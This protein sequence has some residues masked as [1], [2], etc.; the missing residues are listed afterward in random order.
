MEA[1]NMHDK[2]V[3]IENDNGTSLKSIRITSDTVPN[4]F[5]GINPQQ[6]RCLILK[7]PENYT[8]D[9][10]SSLRQNLA[11]ELFTESKWIVLT[12]L[13]NQF[14]D[15]FDDLILSIYSKIYKNADASSYVAEFLK[16]YYKWS[17][18]FME[19]VNEGL[20]DEQ[21]KGLFGELAVLFELLETSNSSNINDVVS[22]WK[23]PFDTGHDF[24][25]EDRTIEVKTKN[26]SSSNVKISSEYQ[27]QKD[28]NKSLELIV[29][30]V[31]IDPLNGDSL[32]DIVFMIREHIISKIG[33]YTI[34]LKALARKGL[35]SKNLKEYNHLKFIK[36]SIVTYDCLSHGFP[37]LIRSKLPDS[38]NSVSYS[39]NLS[40]LQEYIKTEKN[41]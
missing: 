18:F 40:Q 6:Q 20:S 23:G 1:L 38:L 24:I 41:F 17:E 28:P 15:L 21:I 10:Q 39:L 26:L 30:N 13:D 7:L 35:T 22:S 12:L 2:W 25:E 5:I 16:T 11:L 19:D 36:N 34:F 31:T 33:D 9:F 37:M 8:P 4:L 29:V 14:F 27:L 32:E 3:L